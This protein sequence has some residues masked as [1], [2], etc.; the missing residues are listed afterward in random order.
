MERKQFG[1]LE[2]W[3]KSPD[4]KPLVIRGARQ[5]GKSTL[6]RLFAE[7]LKLQLL[8]VNLERHP[9]LNAVFQTMDPAMILD[10]LEALPG[11]RPVGADTALFLDEIQAAPAAIAA[12]RYFYEERRDLPVLSAGSLMEFALSDQKLSM[13]VGRIQYLHMG[14][15]TFMEYLEALGESK[16]K[17]ALESYTFGA[18]LGSI[19]HQRLLNL[20]RHYYYIG[21]MPEAVDRYVRHGR[22]NEVA[23]VHNSIIETCREDF[24]KYARS[25]DLV[26]MRHVLNF[27]ARNV[28][29][30]VKY[31]NVLGDVSSATIR[32]DIELLVKARAISKVVS[33]SASGLPLQ[34]DLDERVY[35]LLF[36]DV[37]LM[38]AVCGLGWSSI[39]RLEEGAINDG[40]IAEQF[41]GQHLLELLADSP[42]RDLTYWL[43]EGKATNAEVDFVVAFEGQIVPIEVK[44]GSRGRLRSLHQFAAEK[45]IRLAVRFD[46]N[47]PSL[48]EVRAPVRSGDTTREV[49][50]QLLSLPLYLVERTADVVHQV[51]AALPHPPQ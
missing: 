44:S 2:R 3:L 48:Q 20:L 26:R 12:L 1:F 43:R 27:S 28:G 24:H 30:K 10:Q 34:A 16:L 23:E 40:A 18:D 33:T 25:R 45:H 5:T 46:T 38:N 51:T 42:N 32:Q 13:P 19:V 49:E 50:Y 22:L 15:M 14:P 36:L 37:G 21:G 11:A 6:V 35:K 4:R 29:T 31:S 17:G 8:E 9:Q 47:P 39:S 41:V 7:Q